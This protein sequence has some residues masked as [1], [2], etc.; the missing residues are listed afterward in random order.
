MNVNSWL[1][2]AILGCLL[3]ILYTLGVWLRVWKMFLREQREER[4]ALKKLLLANFSDFIEA[5]R[6]TRY[7]DDEDSAR[8]IRRR[9]TG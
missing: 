8:R 3:G 6:G 9:M 7:D 1:L 4:E 5:F 2:V